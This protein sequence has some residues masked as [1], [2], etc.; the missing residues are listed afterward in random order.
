MNYCPLNIQTGYSFLS[1]SLR[2]EDIFIYSKKYSY[3]SFG[4]NDF[5]SISCFSDLVK[6]S[7]KYSF[8]PIYGTKINVQGID[9]SIYI[10]DE[11]GYFNLIHLINLKSISFDELNNHKDGLVAI[12]SFNNS[13]IDLF[14]KDEIKFSKLI[15][16]L[17]N[18]FKAFYL[19][20]EIYSPHDKIIM[21]KFRD[22]CKNHNFKMVC[23]NK[24]LYLRKDDAI[25]LKI[26][27]AIKNNLKLSSKQ[28]TGP[29]FFLKP[30][31]LK[32]IYTDE[33]IENTFEIYSMCKDFE[34][35]KKRGKMI[36]FPY[37]DK[38]LELK[39]RCLA[40]L[41]KLNLSENQDYLSRLDYELNTIEKMGYLDYFFIVS[42]YVHF[43]KTNDILTGPGRGSAA[44][45]L[46]SF[47]L[48]ITEIDPIK[49]DLL[50]ERFLNPE[51]VSL[52][53]IDVDFIDYKRPL[54]FSY[55]QEKYSKDR[56]AYIVTYQT[57][58]ARSI[59]QDLS[60][61]FSLDSRD[62][63][64]I[65]SVLKGDTFLVNKDNLSLQEL[66]KDE[67]FNQIITFGEKL[68][69]LPRQESIHASG[70][71][72]NDTPLPLSIPIKEENNSLVSLFDAGLL[73]KLNYLKMDILGLTN[74]SIIESQQE[75]LKSM[76]N[77]DISFSNVP[78]D[79]KKTF[80]ILNQGLTVGLFQLESEGMTKS[81]KLV[82]I[83]SF[84][85]VAAL[86]A[87]YRPG[88]IN[89][90][91]TYAYNKHHIDKIRYLNDQVKPILESTYGIII[92]QEQ[93]ML[94]SEILASFSLGKAD[95]FRRA[96]SKKDVNLLTSLKDEFIDG[97]LSNN[98]SKNEAISIYQTIEKFASYGFNKSHAISYSLISYLMTYIKANYPSCFYL[99]IL[100]HL[101]LSDKRIK[102]ILKELSYFN[103]QLH[104]PSISISQNKYILKDNKIY[105]PFSSIRGINKL[106]LEKIFLIQ[107]EDISTFESFLK[108]CVKH[109]LN[110]ETIVSLINAGAIDEYNYSRS[111][112]RKNYSK[113]I[114]FYTNFDPRSF[115]SIE[116]ERM[117]AP[118]IEIFDEDED[119]KDSLEKDSLS[120]VL[121]SLK[122]SKYLKYIEQNNLLTLSDV[123]EI[124][125]NKRVKIF[126]FIKEM[127]TFKTR[128]NE[129]MGRLIIEDFEVSSNAILF[130]SYY[131]QY[132]LLIKENKPYILEGYFT[133]DKN[134]ARSFIIEK[135]ILKEELQ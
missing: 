125:D 55:L 72:L 49:Y 25:L 3:V 130:P 56:F 79:D 74:L 71:I 48:N 135:L 124:E 73:E 22:Y 63:N 13:L 90:I 23:F 39:N 94:L 43:A 120:I 127:Q 54:I 78:L 70:I 75:Y 82:S 134:H 84:L 85:D 57:F 102:N 34:F 59:L 32:T 132:H 87:L 89:N 45:S 110:E 44:G 46:V 62:V 98:L 109:K 10:A 103:L 100:N 112:L 8:K 128:R 51:R 111:T 113:F 26:L 38:K 41:Q 6:Y 33:E 77:I 101:S 19:G 9:L 114:A 118:K 16:S 31:A 14:L 119:L 80:D 123:R 20:N 27:D 106:Q 105:I 121:T 107:K 36:N 24:H 99:G 93:I 47:L 64:N 35:I 88:P 29:Y 53:D 52:P 30:Q 5:K 104:L 15:F 67:Y 21:D 40:R 37:K 133:Y 50:F 81:L 68:E 58:K 83:D 76:F 117:F 18:G 65:V 61:V 122:Q 66:R 95:I 2:V 116:E 91:S 42:D 4:V 69:F 115:T 129:E 17:E 126:C 11:T 12:L 97:C 131:Q 28:E 1:S 7:K 108:S 86:E 92:Y 60:R 96:I